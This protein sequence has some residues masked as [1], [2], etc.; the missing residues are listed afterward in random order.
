MGPGTL[1][2]GAGVGARCSNTHPNVERQRCRLAEHFLGQKLAEFEGA[3]GFIVVI[4]EVEPFH[5]DHNGL[6]YSITFS[7]V[8]EYPH[9]TRV[10]EVAGDHFH[11]GHLGHA[12]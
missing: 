12:Q 3:G 4:H 2:P 10:G 1:W 6:G 9:V 5:G 8:G 7:G 11:A